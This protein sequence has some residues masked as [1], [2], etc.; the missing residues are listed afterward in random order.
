MTL[1]VKYETAIYKPELWFI[2]S[3]Q[4]FEASKANY[5]LYSSIHPPLSDKDNIRKTGLMCSTLLLLGFATEN[6][7]KGALVYRSPPDITNG[8]LDTKHFGNN[9]HDLIQTARKLNLLNIP[10]KEESTL[11]CRLSE[12]IIWAARY[13][14]P[15]YKNKYDV[16]QSKLTLTYP[17][18]FDTIEKLINAL[19]TE[20]GF[21]EDSGW[22]WDVLIE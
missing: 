4:L 5:E 7:L 8:R 14:A 21:K 10:S 18:D 2:K 16:T 12:S 6:A 1:N 11:L 3:W 20:S 22:D 17:K 15:T 9:A 19:Q 13:Q